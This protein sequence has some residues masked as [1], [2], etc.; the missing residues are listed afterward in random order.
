MSQKT[1]LGLGGVIVVFCMLIVWVFVDGHNKTQ[2][3]LRSLN[4]ETGVHVVAEKAT[5]DFPTTIHYKNLSFS[6]GPMKDFVLT[7]GDVYLSKSLN[8]FSKDPV[9]IVMTNIKPSVTGVGLGGL[10]TAGILDKF[11]VDSL[12]TDAY[13]SSDK[14]HGSFPDLQI[15]TPML[16][17][18]GK[19]SYARQGEKPAIV[20]LNMHFTAME[21]LEQLIGKKNNVLTI[22]GS[23]DNPTIMFDGQKM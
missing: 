17:A 12:S 4:T 11:E 13:L 21:D 3:I 14:S 15:A 6:K 22:Q 10:I 5:F 7:I 20:Q 8:P 16:R 9:H 18:H 19:F 1:K 23:S 2:Q